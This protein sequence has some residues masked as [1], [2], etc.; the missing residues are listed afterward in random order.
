MTTYT[1][2]LVDRRG[3]TAHETSVI[4]ASVARVF[5]LAFAGRNDD[6]E[7]SEGPQLYT[8]SFHLARLE[9][10]GCWRNRATALGKGHCLRAL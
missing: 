5:G 2:K 6:V 10:P 8:R 7:N 3:S 9:G 4:Q 1:V